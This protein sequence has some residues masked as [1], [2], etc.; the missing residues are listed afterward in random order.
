MNNYAFC[1]CTLLQIPYLED[2]TQILLI[3]KLPSIDLQPSG[4]HFSFLQKPV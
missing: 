2:W 3:I 4:S 1:Y